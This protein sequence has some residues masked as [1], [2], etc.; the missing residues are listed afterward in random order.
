MYSFIQNYWCYN[1]VDKTTA[2]TDITG[3]KE[4]NEKFESF[5]SEF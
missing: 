1:Q 4:N 3:L 2:D 5:D